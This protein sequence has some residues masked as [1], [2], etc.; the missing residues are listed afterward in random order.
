[1]TVSAT[2]H[3]AVLVQLVLTKRATAMNK[4]ELDTAMTMVYGNLGYIKDVTNVTI[5]DFKD[6]IVCTVSGHIAHNSAKTPMLAQI[7][8]TFD[9]QESCWRIS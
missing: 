6:E 8:L 1:M 3:A 5:D 2:W 4:S 7:T 9:K